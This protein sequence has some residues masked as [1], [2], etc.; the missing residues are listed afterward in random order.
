M[1]Y[2]K[3]SFVPL[4]QFRRIRDAN[5]QL[6]AW[7]LGPAG[8]RIHGTT[9]ERPLT[10][11]AQTER[12]FLKPLPDNP[13][14][15]AAWAK[16]KVHGDC[17]VQFEKCRYSVPY[18]LVRQHLWLRASPTTG[19]IYQN[20][21]LV[22][23]HTRKH[24]PGARSTLKEHLPLEA[25]AFLMCDPQWC[26]KKAQ[27]IGPACHGLINT[28]FRDRVLDNLRAAQGI[29]R[30]SERYGTR[31]LEAACDRALVFDNPATEV[32]KASSKKAWTNA[33]NQHRR[34]QIHTPS[35]QPI[36]ERDVS[37]AMPQPSSDKKTGGQQNEPDA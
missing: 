2:I 24:A 16:V 7:I 35:R 36:R 30:L 29:I 23:V 37:V 33:S 27:T 9:H 6:Q 4:R 1:K 13:L 15:Q 34:P 14:E 5:R 25:R 26:L 28:L 10:R 3:R 22:A 31:R 17:H 8:N 11:F 32:S 20:H 18:T 21:N 19:R 12:E